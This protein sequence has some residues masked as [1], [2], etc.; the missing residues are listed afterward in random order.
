LL[1]DWDSLHR[2][3]SKT[4]SGETTRLDVVELHSTVSV[5]LS[6]GFEGCLLGLL[7]GRQL[8][9]LFQ[10]LV[11]IN[12]LLVLLLSSLD[13]SPD[14]SFGQ[15]P[16]KL[17]LALRLLFGKFFG[18]KL[19]S[20]LLSNL[21]GFFLFLLLL[22][23]LNLL[24][25]VLAHLLNG[26]LNLLLLDS[27]ELLFATFRFSTSSSGLRLLLFSN[28]GF[29]RLLSSFFSFLGLFQVSK[30]LS[31][32]SINLSFIGCCSSVSLLLLGLGQRC[33]SG[34]SFRLLNLDYFSIFLS[35]S[36]LLLI[37]LL[38]REFVVLS[39]LNALHLVINRHLEIIISVC[40]LSELSIILLVTI[41]E[42]LD[43]FLV[44]ASG[45]GVPHM[46]GILQ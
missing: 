40:L 28:S 41:L 30:S 19:G 21:P 2:Y 12:F 42:V 32:L 8:L 7:L 35:G 6:L 34:L 16:P 10:D 9:L 18:G 38:S 11:E 3:L 14:L 17:F 22:G 36:S 20:Q 33:D 39:R 5:L 37:L 15:F 13:L 24:F 31:L 27:D 29:F 46:E 26:D 25:L 23:V 45:L 43:G 1:L 44:R 4:S